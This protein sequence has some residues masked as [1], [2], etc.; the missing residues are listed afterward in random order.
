MDSY[1][2]L[3]QK[4]GLPSQKCGKSVTTFIMRHS[5]GIIECDGSYCN[6]CR[7]NTTFE[8]SPQIA[9]CA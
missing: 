7:K 2:I 5:R 1:N 4:Y 3:D 8:T 6:T 9:A